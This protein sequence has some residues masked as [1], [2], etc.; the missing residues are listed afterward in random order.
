MVL[1]GEALFDGVR[2]NTANEAAKRV[3][4]E[5]VV[6]D[7]VYGHGFS[8]GIW[9]QNVTCDTRN[10]TRRTGANTL[11]GLDFRG[12]FEGKWRLLLPGASEPRLTELNPL[13]L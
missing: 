12:K 10:N 4:G 11:T 9:T 1:A 5:D 2:Q 3:L 13:G 6:S 8:N 7:V